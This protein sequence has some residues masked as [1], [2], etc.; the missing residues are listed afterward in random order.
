VPVGL[1]FMLVLMS[2]D[3]R[4]VRKGESALFKEDS[5]TA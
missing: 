4:K 3:L 5:P 2:L 1:L